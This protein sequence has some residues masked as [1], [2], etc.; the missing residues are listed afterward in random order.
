[1]SWRIEERFTREVCVSQ[2]QEL[3]L[4]GHNIIIQDEILIWDPERRWAGIFTDDS[5]AKN[6]N[7]CAHK[8]H[9]SVGRPQ[10]LQKFSFCADQSLTEVSALGTER[11]S[12]QVDFI[13]V[14]SYVFNTEVKRGAKLTTDHCLAVTWIRWWGRM[15]RP[16][17]PKHVVRVFGEN[18]TAFQKRLKIL[19]PSGL[20]FTPHCQS[21]YRELRRVMDGCQVSNSKNQMVNIRGEGSY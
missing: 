14:W 20:C 13:T 19:S 17:V 5:W 6:T 21:S 4:L 9:S 3:H 18:L 16:G 12:L 7:H 10:D 8:T 1:M 15:E 11:L 2:K